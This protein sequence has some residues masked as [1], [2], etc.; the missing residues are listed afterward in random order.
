M[1]KT[2]LSWISV[3]VAA[4]ALSP[5]T[6]Q[7]GT[8]GDQGASAEQSSKTAPTRDSIDRGAG[9]MSDELQAFLKRMAGT[10]RT[11]EAP[12]AIR[13]FRARVAADVRTPETT[14]KIEVGIDYL[15]PVFLRTE[16]VENG[17]SIV[18]GRDRG[19]VPWMKTG[20]GES[21]WL[22]GKERAVDREAVAR[23]LA[24]AAGMT[25]FLYPDRVLAQL[26]ETSGPVEEEH[27]WRRD[28]T[29]P[30]YRVTGIAKDGSDFPLAATPGYSGKL[31]VTAW[32]DR[33]TLALKTILLEPLE[34]V[35][36]A[37]A[38]R[39]ELRFLDHVRKDGLL[40]PKKVLLRVEDIDAKRMRTVQAI[41]LIQFRANP[42][43]LT[44]EFFK[45]P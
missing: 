34:E 45:K 15:A 39:E 40:L 24:I 33:E 37:R 30:S 5:V 2:I 44:K 10:I 8:S 11:K 35:E 31:R 38:R 19:L 23:D 20:D 18:R 13:S 43:V 42:L 29:I 12:D 22:E 16:V 27:P 32:F 41:E 7:D 9:S 6:A 3:A 36:G 26:S 21:Y 4:T 14:A 1:S 25:R 28:E 17:T